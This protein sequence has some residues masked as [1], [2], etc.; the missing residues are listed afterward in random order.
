M[1]RIPAPFVCETV[2]P[3]IK[4]GKGRIVPYMES[5]C[6]AEKQIIGCP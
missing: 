4:T 1:S 2:E 5:L 6:W 3:V